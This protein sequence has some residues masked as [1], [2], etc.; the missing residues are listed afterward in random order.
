MLNN[1]NI[2]IK[3]FSYGFN[4]FNYMQLQKILTNKILFLDIET[5]PQFSHWDLVPPKM[6]VLW[7][8]KTEW[9]REKKEIS[10]SDFYKDQAGILAEF[11][12]IICISCGVIAENNTFRVKSFYGNDEF[13]LLTDFQKLLQEKF[14]TQNHLLCAHNG[15]EFDFPYIARRMVINQIPLPGLLDLHGKKPWE[16]AHLDT[17]ELWKFGDYKHYISIDLLT[18]ILDI[19]TPK[20][21]IDGSMVASLYYKE[22]ALEKIKAYCEKDV[23]AVAQIFRKYRYENLLTLELN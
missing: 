21:E 18:E 7:A 6:Q 16:I 23:L 1:I 2:F 8:K 12:K 19:P 3:L 15:K 20:E 14:N 5:V 9:Q 17:L 13:K 10:A 4:S 11:G 22:N